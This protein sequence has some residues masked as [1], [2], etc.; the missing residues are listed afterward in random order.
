MSMPDPVGSNRWPSCSS[1]EDTDRSKFICR[2]SGH[3][4]EIN[5]V[6]ILGEDGVTLEVHFTVLVDVDAG[7]VCKFANN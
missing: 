5:E 1:C 4:P 6:R 7:V 3:E 2:V